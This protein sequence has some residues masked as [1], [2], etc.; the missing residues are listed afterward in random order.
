MNLRALRTLIEIDRVGS[1]AVAAERLGLTLSAVSAQMKTLEEELGFALFDRSRRPPALTP[2]GRQTSAHARSILEEVEAVRALGDLSGAV[3]GTFR[4]GFVGTASV[5]LMPAFLAQA[6]TAHPEAA[7]IVESGLSEDLTARV[8]TGDLDGAV[9]T[10]PSE[11]PR[12]LRFLPL[13]TERFAL[14]A[15]RSAA[16]WNLARCARTLPFIQFRPSSGIGLL[17]DRH[18]RQEVGE[19]TKSVVLDNVESVMGCVNAGIGFA[20]T[21]EPDARRYGANAAVS[22]LEDPPLSRTLALALRSDAPRGAPLER[23][24]ELMAG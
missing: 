5:R 14:A 21:P 1:F 17:V 9:V 22:T 10:A 16:G 23:F 11:A 19:I 2:I 20:V 7:F 4:L 13:R 3:R 24:A 8:Q 18:L 15:P 6:A 12:G